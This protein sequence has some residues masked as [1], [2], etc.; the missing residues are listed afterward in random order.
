MNKEIESLDLAIDR[1]QKEKA[2]AIQR[3][4]ISKQQKERESLQKISS[5]DKSLI[6]RLSK[7]AKQWRDKGMPVKKTIKVTIKA[8]IV[9]TQD[10]TPYID[11]YD[12]YFD[13]EIFDFDELIRFELFEKELQKAK[14]D[15]DN[16]CE[17]SD[18]LQEKYGGID[19]KIFT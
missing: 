4:K 1:L 12:F 11:G 5:K 16:I 19:L 13:G 7:L 9:W 8:N 2:K 18:S 3:A 6:T 10:K 17:R 14:K 15:I